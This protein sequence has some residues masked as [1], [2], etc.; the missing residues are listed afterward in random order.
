[1]LT[2]SWLTL[3]SPRRHNIISSGPLVQI[4]PLN[5]CRHHIGEQVRRAGKDGN[6]Q[7]RHP[8]RILMVE[9]WRSP[10]IKC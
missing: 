4:L 10:I 2:P 3:L 9:T 1:M 8:R 7:L 6:I 5:G